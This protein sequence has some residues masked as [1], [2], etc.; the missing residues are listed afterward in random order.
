MAINQT[1]SY[2]QEVAGKKDF[3]RNN[4]FRI[5]SLNCRNLTLTEEDLV[6]ARTAK[7]PSRETPV[8]TN[9]KYMGMEM[10]YTASTVK[11]D[12]TNYDIEFY[13]DANGDLRNKFERASR[14]A[15]NDITS[16]GNWQFPSNS[17]TMTLALLNI[18]LD[19]IEYYH[20]YGVSFVKIGDVEIQ[21]ADGDGTAIMCRCTISYISYK[22]TGSDTVFAGV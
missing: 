20:F 11:Y 14:M 16:T 18:N 10:P 15:F 17:E 4:L 21:P 7:L 12:G 8:G 9:V 22:S 6:Y 13:L 3:A 2:F 19:P 1:I 5:M